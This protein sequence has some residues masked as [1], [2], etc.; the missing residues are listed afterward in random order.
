MRKLSVVVVS[1][2]FG[3]RGNGLEGGGPGHG[4]YLTV[5]GIVVVYEVVCPK[6]VQC[7]LES[8]NVVLFGSRGARV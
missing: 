3:G 8:G 1:V 5:M 2:Y 6:S 4:G 7:V